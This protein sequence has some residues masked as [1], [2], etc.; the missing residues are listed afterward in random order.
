[1][2]EK[3]AAEIIGD[4]ATSSRLVV[5]PTRKSD[6]VSG[7]GSCDGGRAVVRMPS[8]PVCDQR[9][10]VEADTGLRVGLW[11]RMAT[12]RFGIRGERSCGRRDGGRASCGT[13]AADAFEPAADANASSLDWGVVK[14]LW[15]T[16]LPPVPQSAG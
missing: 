14:I 3:D 5:A 4:F 7:V 12:V 8:M 1:M 6:A 2:V 16:E 15:A 11:L 13:C 10:S 9:D